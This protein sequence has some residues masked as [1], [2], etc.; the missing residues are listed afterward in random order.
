MIVDKNIFFRKG[1]CQALA[2]ESDLELLDCDPAPNLVAAI[3]DEAPD[4]VLLDIGYPLLSGLGLCREIACNSLPNTSVVIL[5]ANP[6]DEELVEVIKSGATGYLSKN[7]TVEDLTRTIRRAYHGEYPIND[8]FAAAP[9]AAE[10]VLRQFRDMVL[11]RKTARAVIAPLTLREREIIDLIARGNSN[12]MIGELLQIRE[13]TIKN[14]VTN[15]F[16]KLNARNRTEAVIVGIR[17]GWISL[18]QELSEWPHPKTVGRPLQ[19]LVVDD[20]PLIGKLFKDS[21]EECGYQVTSTVNSLEA[22]ALVT[23]RHFNFVFLDLVMPRLD[24]SE[25]FHRIRQM[26]KHVPIA[27]I[28]GYPDSDLMKKTMEEGPFLF[29][30]KPFDSDDILGAIHSYAQTTVTKV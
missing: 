22:L 16:H 13:Q 4:V 24:G 30:K 19:I 3:E 26:D 23:Q 2:Q 11:N 7:A 17:G 14:H 21:L 8:V 27:I 15:L 6:D 9:T 28:T 20:E 29:M 5:S 10:K 1:L 12:K 25:L 18:E